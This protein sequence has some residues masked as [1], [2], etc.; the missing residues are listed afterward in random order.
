MKELKTNR[1][2][3]ATALI[4]AVFLLLPLMP[5]ASAR[6]E[7]RT[8]VLVYMVASDLESRNEAATMDL[9]E[10]LSAA[11]SFGDETNLI[12]YAGGAKQWH[13]DIFSSK[14]N[15]CVK[16]DKSGA[17]LLYADGRRDMTNPL[18]LAGF[19]KYCGRHYHADRNILILWDHGGGVY[20]FG[21]DEL[22]EYNKP[23][24]PLDMFAALDWGGMNFDIIGFDACSMASFEVAYSI[25]DYG[26]YMV[27]SEEME[28][29]GGWNYEEWLSRLAKEPELDSFEIA[30]SIVDSYMEWCQDKAPGIKSTM[31]VIDLRLCMKV[32]P[33]LSSFSRDMTENILGGSFDIVSMQRALNANMLS[34][35]QVDMIDAIEFAG[36]FENEKAKELEN[37]LRASVIYHRKAP[38]DL[39]RNGMLIYVPINEGKV[40]GV[41]LEDAESM[42]AVG[43]S[44][45]YIDWVTSFRKYL[46]VVRTGE[47]QERTLLDIISGTVRDDFE[48][49]I[50]DAID[51]T[52]L[53]VTD[54]YITAD[55][56]YMPLLVMPE[57]KQK[58][59]AHVCQKIYTEIDGLLVDYGIFYFEPED[60]PIPYEGFWQRMRDDWLFINN[61]MCPFYMEEK[62]ELAN[63]RTAVYGYTKMCRNGDEGALFLRLVYDEVDEI[64]TVEPLCFQKVDFT[65]Q[66]LQ[67]GRVEPVSNLNSEDIVYFCCSSCGEKADET[68]LVRVTEDMKWGDI[69]KFEL[70][71][72]GELEGFMAAYVAIDL[73]ANVYDLDFR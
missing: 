45:S 63:G 32:A 47:R 44:E 13:N 4:L 43:I 68:F 62:T 52:R 56:N 21:A 61:I 65:Q 73:Y 9:T 3:A 53:D 51:K 11:K 72:T 31:S 7:V 22:N 15:R 10:M 50:Y 41:H 39:R 60:F 71:R 33:A 67:F 49:A 8:N 34:V 69:T 54:C 55:E 48:Q 64:I 19:I 25:C 35:N 57:E 14:E 42:R 70:K 5:A 26:R 28:L 1:I 6:N 17:T 29:L 2:F 59:T 38:A 37:S 30:E 36:C 20:G 46:K 12:V 23:M 40:A 18:T 24:S 66:K 27:A 58:L 16:I